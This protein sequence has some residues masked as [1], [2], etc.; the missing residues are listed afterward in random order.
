M[1]RKE[2][3]QLSNEALDQ[4]LR[5][6]KTMIWIFI[7]LILALLYFEITAYQNEGAVSPMSIITL[8]TIGGLISLL[9]ELNK[10]KEEKSNRV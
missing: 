9:P 2:I 7:P 4:K 8:C 10:L 5:T 6:T 1:K 3:A